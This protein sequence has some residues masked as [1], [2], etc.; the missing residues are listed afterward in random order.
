MLFTMKK[1]L[2]VSSSKILML[3]GLG[4]MMTLGS[5]W[6]H[7][8]NQA[9]LDRMNVL[10]HGVGTCFNRISQT[11]TAMM[12]KDIQ[13]PYLNRGFMGLSDECLNEAIKGINP[14]K[15]SVGKGYETLNKL[16]SD[17]HWFHESLVRLHTPMLIGKSLDAPLNP[18]S[19]KFSA[20]EGLKVNLMD[21]IDATNARLSQVQSNDEV[22]MGV[23]LIIFVIALS[24]L[25]LQEFNRIQL[26]KEIEAQALNLLRAGQSNV[27]GMVDL[28]IERGLLTQGL[29]VSAQIFK[30]YHGDILERMGSK[31]AY[32]EGMQ[33]KTN[34]VET[35][36]EVVEETA[37]FVEPEVFNG[38]RTS[39]K[40][41][42][43]SLK[44]I[45]AK[46][47]IQESDVREVQLNVG[48]EG[49]EQ[50][51]NA[52]INKLA[53]RRFDNKKIMISNQVHSD[54][55]IINLFLAGNTF[56][57]SELDFAQNNQSVSADTMDMNMIIMKEMAL[58]TNTSWHMENKTDRNGV[59]TGMS[60]RFTV[61]RVPK[62]NKS[63]KN[64][65]SVVKG[66]KKDLAREM[67][68]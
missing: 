31:V 51:M 68:N 28:L 46:D 67:M 1:L 30:E 17:V 43:V 7:Q 19:T 34:S 59:I 38:P 24:L 44:N 63:N 21:E 50:M 41:V 12:I 29:P 45:N 15:Q 14:F 42:L 37:A 58:E 22:V 40:E 62:D 26:R 33:T 9:Q 55:A 47:L 18:I 25:S 48:F 54:R 10:N 56:T 49:F 52:A 23:G 64:L 39:L 6:H 27:G 5:F 2:S 65:V 32:R 66:K 57:A 16:I 13:S 61:N 8:T 53:S 4:L 3:C 11:F 36:D 20:M 60:L 35:H